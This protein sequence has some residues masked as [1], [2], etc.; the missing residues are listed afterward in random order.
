MPLTLVAAGSA[1]PLPIT[2][3]TIRSGLSNA[4]HR[5]APAHS[6]ARRPHGSIPVSRPRRGWEWYREM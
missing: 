6:R 4:A 3:A 1:S 5:R 2:H